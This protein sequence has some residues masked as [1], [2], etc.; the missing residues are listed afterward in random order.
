MIK[1]DKKTDIVVI[2]CAM[3]VS[4]FVGFSFGS[5]LKFIYESSNFKAYAWDREPNIINCFGKEF[6]ADAM[7]RAIKF[8]ENR[9]EKIG[10]YDH[11]PP[12]KLCRKSKIPGFII[13][14]KDKGDIS[15]ATALAATKRYTKLTKMVS[16]TIYYKHNNYTLYLLN[17]HEL[18]HALGY[19][20]IK[21]VGHI[22]HP[23]FHLMGPYFYIP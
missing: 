8:W 20:H 11:T 5:S 16:A 10:F 12:K 6:E 4:L 7:N 3:I 13:L 9:G 14:K 19:S 15:S 17:E 22:M 21:K 23:S 2:F 18:G 1:K